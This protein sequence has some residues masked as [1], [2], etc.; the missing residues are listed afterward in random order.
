VF[1]LVHPL[2][3]SEA[4]VDLEGGKLVGE[5]LVA[6]GV[7]VE[8]RVSIVNEAEKGD[9]RLCRSVE[10]SGMVL[11]GHPELPWSGVGRT[12]LFLPQPMTQLI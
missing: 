3:S 10:A 8:Q 2:R 6:T 1:P 7:R 4:T 5:G 12:A 11:V 9:D